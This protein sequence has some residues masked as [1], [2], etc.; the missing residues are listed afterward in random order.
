MFPVRKFYNWANVCVSAHAISQPCTHNQWNVSTGLCDIYTISNLECCK[1]ARMRFHYSSGFQTFLHVDPQLKYTIF[2]RLN[3]WPSNCRTAT[4]ALQYCLWRNKP[5][6]F[7]DANTMDDL[8]K[9]LFESNV[10]LIYCCWDLI[11]PLNIVLFVEKR[12]LLSLPD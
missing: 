1:S 3:G 11:S 7:H 5:N 2:C 4:Y 12:R 10:L 8:K 6:S 9:K